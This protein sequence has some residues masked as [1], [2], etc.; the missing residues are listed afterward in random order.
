MATGMTFVSFLLP[1]MWR[2]CTP[3][4]ADTEG[5]SE[6]EKVYIYTLLSGDHHASCV[7]VLYMYGRLSLCAVVV[8]VVVFRLSTIH[9]TE[10]VNPTP[11][12]NPPPHSS[13]LH[14]QVLLTQLVPFQCQA[15]THY[16][17]LASLFFTD[18]DTAIRQLFHYR[19]VRKGGKM[20]ALCVVVVWM[21]ACL[22]CTWGGTFPL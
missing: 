11:K 22:V 5:W 21:D 1:L 14:L 9:R 19:E 17:E 8:V 3:L 2:K 20:K 12:P 16:N 7:H 18:S 10:R 13:S 15:G 6:Q 4:P